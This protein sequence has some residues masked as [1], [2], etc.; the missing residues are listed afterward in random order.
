MKL[1]F[2]FQEIVA[3]TLVCLKQKKC[4]KSISC[5]RSIFKS[6]SLS[7]FQ[8][9]KA[10]MEHNYTKV[11]FKGQDDPEPLE[12]CPNK[13]GKLC[14]YSPSKTTFH[15]NEFFYEKVLYCYMAIGH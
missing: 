15:F 2:A 5:R 4:R 7:F 9:F 12:K 10:K 11:S 3:L 1:I 8:N 14:F 6:C 13:K